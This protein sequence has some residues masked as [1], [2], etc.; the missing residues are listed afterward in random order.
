MMARQP[1]LEGCRMKT[2]TKIS[3]A[4]VLGLSLIAGGQSASAK[5]LRWDLQNV[6]FEGGGTANGYFLYDTSIEGCFSD[7]PGHAHCV[8]SWDIEI[9]GDTTGGFPDFE[10][11]SLTSGAIGGNI[12]HGSVSI[13]EG[14]LISFYSLSHWGDPIGRQALAFRLYVPSPLTDAGGTVPLGLQDGSNSIPHT[15]EY[16]TYFGPSRSARTGE[17]FAV[18]EPCLALGLALGTIGLV[19][20]LLFLRPCPLSL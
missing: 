5:I 2:S 4:A 19:S 20:R 7:P 15:E 12:P 13:P 18:P 11:T 1:S 3:V 16:W 17:V 8:T 9:P 10:F 14:S 6:T